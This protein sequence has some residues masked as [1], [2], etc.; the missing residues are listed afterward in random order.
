LHC[1]SPTSAEVTASVKVERPINAASKNRY[2]EDPCATRTPT[3]ACPGTR[4]TIGSIAKFSK[5]EENITAPSMQFAELF[6]RLSLG[7][8][9][10][11]LTPV[12]SPKVIELFTYESPCC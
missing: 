9:I 8:R 6:T 7:M 12:F 3:Y 5:A 4:T 2:F 11:W 1:E 10:R